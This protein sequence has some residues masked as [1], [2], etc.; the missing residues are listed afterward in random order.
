[1]FKS[2]EDSVLSDISREA[3]V[4]TSGVPFSIVRCVCVRGDG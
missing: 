2:A 1:M 4:S 3:A